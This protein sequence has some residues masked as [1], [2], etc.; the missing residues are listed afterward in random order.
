MRTFDYLV[1]PRE[2]E[3]TKV[4]NLL[5]AIR[6]YRGK[7]DLWRHAAPAVL[8]ALLESAKIQS[9]GA[10]NRIEGIVTTEKRLHGLVLE[11]I[12]P[13]NRDEEEILGYRD[14]LGLIHEQHDF[15]P[16]TPG[17]ILQL[18]RDLMAHA[19]VTFGGRWKDSDNEIVSLDA[20][21]HTTV[22][23]RPMPAMLTPNA[24]SALCETYN[25]AYNQEVCDPLLLAARFVFDFVSI[26]PFTDGNGRMS[27]LLTVLLM[28][29]AGYDVG[30]YISIEHAIEETKDQY[31]EALAASSSGWIEGA[32]D[33]APFVCYLLGVVLAAY[34]ELEKR[35]GEVA[36]GSVPTKAER[37]R[38]VFERQVGKVT[39][40]MI[41]DACPDVSEVTVKRA[42]AEL[43]REGEIE[44]VGSGPATGYVYRG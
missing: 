27:R 8:E 13:R 7:Q 17:V 14:V 38:Q 30:R 1:V 31:Y 10:S 36:A 19:P 37:V 5:L 34:R 11:N 4:T 20:E 44:K 40:A 3:N 18:H 33:E 23:F 6:E 2:L 28:E 25:Q 29:R 26:H 15:I 9:I 32:N 16:V 39:K 24:V 42:L 35:V 41:L 21:G 43:L 22:R 12:A